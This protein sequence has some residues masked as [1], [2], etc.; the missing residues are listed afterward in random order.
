MKEA[1]T[2][3][4]VNLIGKVDPL[5]PIDKKA[6]A[7][8][9]KALRPPKRKKGVKYCRQCGKPGHMAKTCP[10]SK[11]PEKESRNASEAIDEMR[12]AGFKPISPEKL[13]M[14]KTMLANGADHE[15]IAAETGL[16]VDRIER[17][18]SQLGH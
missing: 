5:P 16:D 1:T 7:K 4:K 15:A 18:A 17:M 9:V 10:S 3:E 2:L 12:G 6:V 8:K 14:V 13:H 11:A